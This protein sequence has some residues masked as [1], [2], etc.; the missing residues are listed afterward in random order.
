MISRSLEIFVQFYLIYLIKSPKVVLMS[1]LV[2]FQRLAFDGIFT[3]LNCLKDQNSLENFFYIFIF[4]KTRKS[5]FQSI[6]LLG[7]FNKIAKTEGI[8]GFYR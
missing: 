7:S 1:C 2:L 4:F 5:E 6:G 8:W 3:M